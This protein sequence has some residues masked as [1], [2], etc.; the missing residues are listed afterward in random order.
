[1]GRLAPVEQS[2]EERREGVLTYLEY[3][4]P[5]WS[6]LRLE[7]EFAKGRDSDLGVDFK[8]V[9][10]SMDRL[11]DNLFALSVEIEFNRIIGGAQTGVDTSPT[12]DP[13]PEAPVHEYTNA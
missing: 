3:K 12:D 1:M 5:A 9:S 11:L 4:R 2:P 13:Y 7:V 8:L 10:N 6:A